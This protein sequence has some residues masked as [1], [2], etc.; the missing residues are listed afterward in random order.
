MVYGIWYIGVFVCGFGVW[1]RD[2][3]GVFWGGDGDGGGRW[4]MGK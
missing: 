3:C 1:M 4:V 2:G